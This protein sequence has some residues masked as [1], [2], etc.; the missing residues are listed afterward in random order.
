MGWRD[1]ARLP[2]GW[3]PDR[4]YRWGSYRLVYEEDLGAV[5][6][7][8]W[9]SANRLDAGMLLAHVSQRIPEMNNWSA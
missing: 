8:T 4:G 2:C 3:D 5:R 6:I 9:C 7:D 1:G